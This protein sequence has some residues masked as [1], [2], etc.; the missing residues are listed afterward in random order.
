MP[1]F[2]NP[3]TGTFVPI[4]DD[5]AERF[6]YNP[7]ADPAQTDFAA[8][9]AGSV[10]PEPEQQ[11]PPSP[12][13]EPTS[14]P[15]ALQPADPFKVDDSLGVGQLEAPQYQPPAVSS[16]QMPP[17]STSTGGGFR[18]KFNP[19]TPP[20]APDY[21]GPL[22][23]Y[24]DASVGMAQALG[25]AEGVL[26]TNAGLR[27]ET[28]AEQNTFSEES[29]Q[30]RQG[31]VDSRMAARQSAEAR[32][33]E[34]MD[35]IPQADPGRVFRNMSGFSK[36]LLL[37]AG[38][39]NG[40]NVR[41]N[42]GKNG[43]ADA[44][45]QIA[46]RDMAAQKVNIDTAREGV[47]RTERAYERENAAWSQ[48]VADH[49]VGVAQ[50]LTAFDR[51]LAGLEQNTQSEINRANIAV[52]RGQLGQ[53][54]AELQMG[55][56]EKE[57]A[58]AVDVWKA[59]MQELSANWRQSQQLKAA[60]EARTAPKPTP[61]ANTFDGRQYGI[62]FERNTLDPDKHV[63]DFGDDKIA[64]EVNKVAEKNSQVSGMIDEV[65][66][67]IGDGGRDLP[68][69]QKRALVNQRLGQV[70]AL[71]TEVGGRSFSDKDAEV[72]T[73]AQAAGDPYAIFRIMTPETIK[74]GLVN[75]QK[76]LISRTEKSVDRYSSTFGKAK[77]NFPK[78]KALI[79]PPPS[80]LD[81]RQALTGLAGEL[82]KGPKADAAKVAGYF[83]A[84]S[85]LQKEAIISP[86]KLAPEK[87]LQLLNSAKLRA[88]SLPSVQENP[89]LQQVINDAADA[90]IE[91]AIAESKAPP[92][93]GLQG[94]SEADRNEK[95]QTGVR[96]LR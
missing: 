66:T 87:T 73:K 37:I 4:Y 8:D 86:G 39:L 58:R 68:G 16:P 34:A 11:L 75:F 51:H 42:Q 14:V 79:D 53:R 52:Q 3:E 21:S 85:E 62:S 65:L 81:F 44:L 70:I 49:D 60:E 56:F 30:A 2:F 13:P 29:A 59:G 76:D 96:G 19:N 67:M 84:F 47:F 54:I 77:V 31:L 26:E 33:Q 45:S 32:I 80:R 15:P 69:T 36:G 9:Q 57:D 1:I 55:I 94:T 10:P 12:A 89:E 74:K 48:R 41:F 72:M 24:S 22:S 64:G 46:D 83:D 25:R 5:A 63:I 28:I 88:L 18:M 50:R 95:F 71:Y 90:A 82:D 35:A 93:T 92:T 23:S 40:A 7:P 17:G 61:L 6:G 20:V 27:D 78:G 43:I 38:A 91:K